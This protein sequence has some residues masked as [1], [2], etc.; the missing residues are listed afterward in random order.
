MQPH[1]SNDFR[2]EPGNNNRPPR[3]RTT[4]WLGIVICALLAAITVN[5]MNR[6]F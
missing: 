4:F 6:L 3:N 2:Q 5:L 1:E